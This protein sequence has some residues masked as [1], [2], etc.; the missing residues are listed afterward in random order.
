MKDHSFPTVHFWL[1][2]FQWIDNIHVGLFWDSQFCSLGLC[3]CSLYQYHAVLI[4]IV[5]QHNLKAGSVMLSTFFLSQD[6]F[7]DFLGGPEFKKLPAIAEDTGLTSGPG[8]FHM[9]RCSL[10]TITEP[11]CCRYEPESQQERR[12][13][14]EELVPHT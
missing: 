11:M 2:C 14:N 6:C 8:R 10:A 7:G 12:H 1:L 5:L 3:V 9:R 4:I 13:R